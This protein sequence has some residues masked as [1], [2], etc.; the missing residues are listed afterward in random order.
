MATLTR[1]ATFN[2]PFGFKAVEDMPFDNSQ[3]LRCLLRSAS[4]SASSNKEDELGPLDQQNLFV[5]TGSVADFYG[6]RFP[7]NKD[8]LNKS[9]SQHLNN[10]LH[11]T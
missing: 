2:V 5:S 1:L 7:K 3:R 6:D 4:L 8:N 11:P 9:C 10:H